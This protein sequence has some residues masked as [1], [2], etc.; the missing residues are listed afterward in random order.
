MFK[1]FPVHLLE[2]AFF[3]SDHGLLSEPVAD[4]LA[5]SRIEAYVLKGHF[6]I[7]QH[8]VLGWGCKTVES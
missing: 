8:E 4:N 6:I 2:G 3:L 5:V 7:A 1:P